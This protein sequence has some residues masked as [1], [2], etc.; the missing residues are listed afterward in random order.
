MTPGIVATIQT[1]LAHAADAQI[2]RVVAMVD[3]MPERGSA[4]ALIA[5]LRPRLAALR[6]TRPLSFTRL[7][8]T[9]LDPVIMTTAQWQATCV[10]VPRPALRPLGAAIAAALSALGQAYHDGGCAETGSDL[11]EA[12]ATVLETL[13]APPDWSAASGLAVRHFATVAGAVGAVLHEAT[14]I[15]SLAGRRRPAQ[16]ETLEAMLSRSRIH[17]T[18][19]LDTVVAVLLARLPAP[20]RTLALAAAA[21]GSDRAIEQTL[22]MLDASLS[23]R[24]DGAR[25]PRTVAVELG[26]VVSLTTALET[27]APPER[28]RR[29]DVIRREANFFCQRSFNRAVEHMLTFAETA[30][31]DRLKDDVVAGLEVTARDLRRLEAVGRTL[32]ADDQYDAILASASA[33]VRDTQGGLSL[34]ERVHLIEILSGPEAAMAL[35]PGG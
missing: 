24:N 28:R 12:A 13:N 19:A 22:D 5:P 7:L 29:L 25:D 21:A 1:S 8:F 34:V 6:P 31:P 15:Q 26:R 9:P 27:A 33:S 30:T 20:G 11:W 10:G 16:D 3:A 2:A 14:Q 35:L 23:S 17:G 18:L 4:D 32:G